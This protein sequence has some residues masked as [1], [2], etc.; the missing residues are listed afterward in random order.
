MKKF[1]LINRHTGE[2]A[3]HEGNT[4]V[5]IEDCD[6]PFVFCFNTEDYVILQGTGFT[7]PEGLEV[8][9]G[10]WVQYSCKWDDQGDLI[11]EMGRVVYENGAFAIEGDDTLDA[12]C[13]LPS[14]T[15]R[16]LKRYEV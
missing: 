9:E 13:Q 1:K 3:P 12:L 6:D 15:I 14:F 5:L 7:D 16:I 10:D 4:A 8:F 2:E 11:T